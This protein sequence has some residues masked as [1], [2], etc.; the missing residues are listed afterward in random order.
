MGG[1]SHVF[2]LMDFVASDSEDIDAFLM[3]MPALARPKSLT[4]VL[5]AA[6]QLRHGGAD[7]GAL[8]EWLLR[9]SWSSLLQ[10]DGHALVEALSAV[11]ARPEASPCAAATSGA[12]EAFL[13]RLERSLG[14]VETLPLEQN[15][16]KWADFFARNLRGQPLCLVGVAT[17]FLVAADIT[18]FAAGAEGGE[19]SQ[20]V[21][22]ALL[23]AQGLLLQHV[24]QAPA[25]RDAYRQDLLRSPWPIWRL[26]RS[27]QQELEEG[28]RYQA[29]GPVGPGGSLGAVEEDSLYLTVIV[30]C[31]ND[32]YGGNM[33]LRLHRMLATTSRMLHSAQVPSEIIV[34]E[35]NP[36][37][38]A[39]LMH[40][41]ITREPGAESV[42]IR[43]IQV[44]TTV[45]MSMPHAKAHPIFE[46]TAENVAFRRAKGK[47]ILKTNI[48]NILSPDTVLFISRQQL[49]PFVVYRATYMEY[50]VTRP[51][52]EG[53]AADAL[54]EW[55][56]SREDLITNMNLEMADL[57]A[58]YPEDAA[59]C[60]SGHRPEEKDMKRPFY[61]PGSGDFVLASKQ[62]ILAVRGYPEVAQ[63][64][65]TDDLIHCRLRAFGARQVVLQ[66]PCLTVHQNHQRINRVRSSTRWVIT[67]KNF[68][69]VCDNP[70]VPLKTEI[71]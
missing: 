1:S 60:M 49:E 14:G 4:P 66:P 41:E 6:A 32:D 25:L 43:I 69:E 19:H 56:F 45:H 47:F 26:M 39:P 46:H 33:L 63:N 53:L 44:P 3:Q 15:E 52:T 31:R 40:E 67:D 42:P 54:I 28:R 65:Q 13:E 59:V 16:F 55:L 17:L 9:L 29:P 57:R 51:E 38:G 23:F 7:E 48:D 2:P 12:D 18:A 62:L 71:G 68:Q 50:D 20:R 10:E 8:A 34:V 64:W 24:E 37:F 36:V 5:D 35:W 61:W 30:Q 70:F 58:K 27:I 22:R 21:E 11:P